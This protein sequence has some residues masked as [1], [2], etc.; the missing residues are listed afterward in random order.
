MTE[1]IARALR[2]A[3]PTGMT[4]PACAD[5]ER[6]ATRSAKLRVPARLRA[7]DKKP[8]LE[9]ECR[10][11]VRRTCGGREGN[12]QE[13]GGSAQSRRASTDELALSAA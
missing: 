12:R 6:K 2:P 7:R 1:Q 4:L 10:A 3:L 5:P 8:E 13:C 9:Q 11:Q